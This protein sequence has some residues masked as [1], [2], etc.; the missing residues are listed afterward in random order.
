[1]ERKVFHYGDG[2]VKRVESRQSARKRE[3]LARRAE[4]WEEQLSPDQ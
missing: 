2:S 3:E 4:Y 1:M